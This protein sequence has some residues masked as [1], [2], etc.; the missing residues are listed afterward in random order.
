MNSTRCLLLSLL[1]GASAP[2]VAG[3]PA[4]QLEKVV[5]SLPAS[6][7]IEVDPQGRVA[8]YAIKDAAAYD[9]SVIAL[10]GRD[11]PRWTFKPVLIDGVARQARF[12]MYLRLEARPL[13]GERYAVEIAS[14]AFGASE[15]AAANTEVSAKRLR[16]LPEYPPREFRD[17]VGGQV[18]L[19]F[20][21]GRSGDVADVV[22]EQT[23]LKAVAGDGAMQQ[24]RED[25]ENAA[26][27]A[28]RRWKFTPPTAGREAG[29]ENF[30]ARIPIAYI[31]MGAK[32]KTAV[33]QWES[34]VPGPRHRLPWGEDKELAADG[35]DAL[36]DGRLFPLEQPLQLLTPLHEG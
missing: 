8:G 16:P 3:V 12:D 2:S 34:Y 15:T 19:V 25:F 24:W 31:P 18:L 27:T 14:A 28:A 10:L 30:Y 11:I 36:P 29:A 4:A 23:N 13:G 1:L 20:R 5:S 22:V 17:G 32:A 7:T 35:A 9:P 26:L 6:G 21:I 33:G